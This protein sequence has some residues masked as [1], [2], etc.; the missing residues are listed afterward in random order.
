M[1]PYFFLLLF[2]IALP[3]S[4]EVPDKIPASSLE[5]SASYYWISKSAAIGPTGL[6]AESFT[7][8]ELA[9]I[10]DR[11]N[12]VANLEARYRPEVNQE[13]DSCI[14]WSGKAPDTGRPSTLEEL[15]G[16]PHVALL[17]T[18]SDLKVGFLGQN[19]ATILE[20]TL[21]EEDAL[22]VGVPRILLLYPYGRIKVNGTW[23][24]TRLHAAE[25]AIEDTLG[26]EILLI[27]ISPLPNDLLLRQLVS[28]EHFEVVV[29]TDK[30]LF[31]PSQIRDSR[32]LRELK[33]FLADP[34]ATKDN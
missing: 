30:S 9:R 29:D 33:T 3:C 23:F 7:T 19:A 15:R 26:K 16:H 34:A 24:C 22:T 6:R 8:A 25:T 13:I 14:V 12:T 18:V 17:G 28:S 11:I 1:R 5:K 10:T 21:E 20:V 2:V 27:S 31:L 32:N 4:G